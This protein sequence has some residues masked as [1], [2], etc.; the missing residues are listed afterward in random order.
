[1][2]KGYI[3]GPLRPKLQSRL[4]RIET[5]AALRQLTGGARDVQVLDGAML[6]EREVAE[7]LVKQLK[8]LWLAA[9]GAGLDN[10]S[11]LIEPAFFEAFVIADGVNRLN[12]AGFTATDT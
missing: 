6:N 4:T 1:M 9:Q 8:S 11:E 2:S 10:I 12:K 3:S 7:H 5:R